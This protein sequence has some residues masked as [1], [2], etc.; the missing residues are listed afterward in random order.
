MTGTLTLNLCSK[1]AISS[2]FLFQQTKAVVTSG[3]LT[4]TMSGIATAKLS[5]ASCGIRRHPSLGRGSGR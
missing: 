5:A 1:I 3:R 4:I 2:L